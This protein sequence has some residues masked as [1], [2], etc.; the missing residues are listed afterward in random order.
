MSKDQGLVLLDPLTIEVGG[1][2]EEQYIDLNLDRNYQYK[3]A[4]LIHNLNVL[5]WDEPFTNVEFKRL[6][7]KE[8]LLLK[9]KKKARDEE[10]EQNLRKADDEKDY[11]PSSQQ[12]FEPFCQE[13][14]EPKLPNKIQMF[15][16]MRACAGAT[17]HTEL[18]IYDN[19]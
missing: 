16:I 15:N 1:L 4:E 14:A 11:V 9:K 19:H 13:M 3:S 5:G 10:D 7:K 8:Q 17:L 18:W 6:D 2:S 12:I